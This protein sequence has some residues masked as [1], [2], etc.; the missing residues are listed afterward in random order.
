MTPKSVFGV[1]IDWQGSEATFEVLVC[2]LAFAYQKNH[3]VRQQSANCTEHHKLVS[4]QERGERRDAPL[5]ELCCQHSDRE[6]DLDCVRSQQTNKKSIVALANA[7][8]KPHTVVV[9][10]Q[11]T[12]ITLC[13]MD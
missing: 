2:G 11:N 1:W 9:V 3:V 6:C 5:E 8:R 13:A 12:V 10:K 4:E 7:G